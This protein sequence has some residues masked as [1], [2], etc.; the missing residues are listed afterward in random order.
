M[1]SYGVYLWHYAVI[2]WLV[3]RIGCHPGA[4]TPCPAT[5][6]WSFVGVSLAAIPLSVAAGAVSWYLVERPC[7]RFTHRP[8]GPGPAPARR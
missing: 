5:V 4:L 8:A 2:E 3:R 6:H 7:I 1:V